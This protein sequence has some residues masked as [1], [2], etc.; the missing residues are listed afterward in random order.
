M[1]SSF[2]LQRALCAN[3][4]PLLFLFLMAGISPHPGSAQPADIPL[5]DFVATDGIVYGITKT[6][7]VIYFGGSFTSVSVT[8]TRIVSSSSGE[9]SSLIVMK[10]S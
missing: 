10:S 9:L 2:F 6:N 1:N 3:W 5:E 8:T 4:V 7:D